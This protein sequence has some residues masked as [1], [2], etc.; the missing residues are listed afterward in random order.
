MEHLRKSCTH[1]LC[2]STTNIQNRAKKW[3]WCWLLSELLCSLLLFINA[4]GDT[5]HFNTLDSICSLESSLVRSSQFHH[6][7]SIFNQHVCFLW[8]W[9]PAF[10]LTICWLSFSSFD[11][12]VSFLSITCLFSV[13]HHFF[14]FWVKSLITQFYVCPFVLADIL[15][16][17]FFVFF[18]FVL[19]LTCL[20]VLK[21]LFE[22]CHC[23]HK[24]HFNVN[25]KS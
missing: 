16:V 2:P 8:S 20:Q 5:I 25:L 23:I 21:I 12:Y 22:M 9:V 3:N 6:S 7:P 18:F 19:R 11:I 1:C 13:D 17:F 24:M 10:V 15:V 14:D 4:V